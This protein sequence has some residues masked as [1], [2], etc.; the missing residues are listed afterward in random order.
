[1][2]SSDSASQEE[3]RVRRGLGRE[4]RRRGRLTAQDSC[5]AGR[6]GK[7]TRP[8]GCSVEVGLPGRGY[9]LL[10]HELIH[11]NELLQRLNPAY[12]KTQ[13]REAAGYTLGAV[14]EVLGAFRPPPELPGALAPA[15][16]VFAGYL[17]FDAVIANTDRHH[18]N[19]AVIQPTVGTA[20]LAISFDHAMCL[21]FQEPVDRKVT[22]LA[23]AAEVLRWVERGRSNHCEGE[24][25]LLELA[26]DGLDRC[27]SA[28][29]G[30][31]LGHL[32]SLSRDDWATT[33]DRV[34]HHL[35]SQVDRTFASAI[36]ERNRERLLD[37]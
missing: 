18:E 31:W 1:M 29:R 12:D 6:A 17:M 16:D 33:I 34:P 4:G 5:G 11:G 28:A 30:H 26:V 10:D 19:W 36:I 7:Q 3:A 20:W 21:G 13:T 15:T 14:W 23:D 35:M 22:L 25:G 37:A 32:A 24:P 27:S 8:A 9:H 2:G